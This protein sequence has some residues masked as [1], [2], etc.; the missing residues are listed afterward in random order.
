MTDQKIINWNPV[1]N[2]SRSVFVENIVDN[3]EGLRI[4]LKGKGQND[5]VLELFFSEKILYR[6]TNESYFLRTIDNTGNDRSSPL[7]IVE[8]SFLI[9]WLHEESYGVYKDEKISHYLIFSGND[10]I[11]VLTCTPPQ[12][13][14]VSN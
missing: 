2:L 3:Y 7:A 13:R 6:N 10:C 14:W 1:D 4:L 12:V 11:D 8:N 9:K 5:K